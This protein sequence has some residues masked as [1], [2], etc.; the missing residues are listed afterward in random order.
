LKKRLTYAITQRAHIAGNIFEKTARQ[1]SYLH[2]EKVEFFFEV[3]ILVLLVYN[4]VQLI[5]TYER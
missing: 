4:I 3:I 1:N 5:Q 2:F